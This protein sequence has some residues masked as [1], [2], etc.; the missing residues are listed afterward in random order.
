[1]PATTP[2]YHEIIAHIRTHTR[3][4]GVPGASVRRLALL[5]TGLIAARSCVLA[6]IAAELD[7]LQLTAAV[8]V[9]SITRRLRRTLADP[10]LTAARCYDQLLPTVIDWTAAGQTDGQ[11][12]LIVDE[13]TKADQVHL[14]RVS[15]AYRGASLPLVWT[16]WRQNVAQEA[17]AYWQQIDAVLARVAALLPPGLAVTVVADRAYECPRFIDCIAAYGWHWLVRVKINSDL[18]FRNQRGVQVRLGTVIRQRVA[19]PG[20]RWKARGAVFKKA[21]WRAASVVALWAS[22]ATEPIGGAERPAAAL[23]SA[24]ALRSAFLGRAGFPQ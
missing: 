24:P 8:E 10:H 5:V 6:Q 22:P 14:F 16:L 9:A 20:Q 15:L 2:L 12:V 23:G 11:V 17:G 7:A 4:A 18:R 13:S 1:M 21:G 3:S 19:Q